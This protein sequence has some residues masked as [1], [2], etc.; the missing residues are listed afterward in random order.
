L[1]EIPDGFPSLLEPSPIPLEA[2]SDFPRSLEN[3]KP[4]YRTWWENWLENRPQP[5]VLSQ[6]VLICLYVLT[7]VDIVLDVWLE[8]HFAETQRY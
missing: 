3:L 7:I 2:I 6:K 5:P 1:K 4:K 8:E